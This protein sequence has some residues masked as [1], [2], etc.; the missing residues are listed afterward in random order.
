[1]YLLEKQQIPIN[2]VWFDPPGLEPTIYCTPGDNDH[3]YTT[4]AVNNPCEIQ[5]LFSQ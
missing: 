2:S 1:V 4:D 3:H 5:T